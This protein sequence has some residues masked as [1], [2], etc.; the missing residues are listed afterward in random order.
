[1]YVYFVQPDVGDIKWGQR[2]QLKYFDLVLQFRHLLITIDLDWKCILV[3][4]NG[5]V[6]GVRH[7]G[8]QHLRVVLEFKLRVHGNLKLITH[9][10]VGWFWQIGR[11]VAI[12]GGVL[13]GP[14]TDL[15]VR[16]SWVRDSVTGIGFGA[17][18]TDNEVYKL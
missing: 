7:D 6:H 8:G 16:G 11:S 17:E 4:K 10:L 15:T 12:P 9:H 18:V 1:M 13:A 5:A 3:A 14:L 2:L